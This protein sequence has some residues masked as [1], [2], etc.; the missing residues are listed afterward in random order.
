MLEQLR[1]KPCVKRWFIAYSGGLDSTVLLHLALNACRHLPS[2][3]PV[4]AL[5]IN[6]QLSP[7]AHHWQQHCQQQCERLGIVFTC[8]KVTVNAQGKGLEAAA[9]E[10]RYHVFNQLLSETDGLLMGHHLDDQ[11]ETFILRLMRGSGVLGLSAMKPER[12]LPCGSVLLRPLLST[13][14][15]QLEAY[16]EHHHLQWVEDE[17]NQSLV[18][19]RNFVRHQLVPLIEERWPKAK[20]QWVKTASHLHASQT[21]LYELADLDLQQ[22]GVRTERYGVSIRWEKIKHL[23]EPRIA[24]L[25][26][27]WCDCLQMSLPNQQQ[28]QYIYQQFFSSPAVLSSVLVRWG[29]CELR[30]F[31]RRLF[32]MKPLPAFIESPVLIEK[33][34]V[35]PWEKEST[36]NLATAGQ[37]AICD[38]SRRDAGYSSLGI[39]I[40][41][42]KNKKLS[43]QWRKGGERCTP[44]KRVSSQTLKK[45]LQEYQLETWLRDRVPLIYCENRL[46]AVG[47][48]WVCKAYAASTDEPAISLRW[49]FPFV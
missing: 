31:N 16:A 43:I 41:K 14:R 21:L 20:K 39:A 37:L 36:I 19:D 32:L 17:S 29:D 5:H 11:A 12:S 3:L 24:N 26:R 9:R 10:Q 1:Q 48:L 33:A 25:L 2:P 27:Y 8:H 6:H 4:S 46:V 35:W 44:A 49:S 18:F 23:S 15:Q 28:M 45:L 38:V 34:L 30:Q 40:H 7:N 42:I 13:S 47:D 22:S